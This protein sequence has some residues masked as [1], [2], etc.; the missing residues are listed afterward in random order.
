MKMTKKQ[1][2]LLSF[3][4]D[5][6][7]AGGPLPTLREMM[8]EF[9][10]SSTNGADDHVTALIRHGALRR[11]EARRGYGIVLTHPVVLRMLE[12]RKASA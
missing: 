12:E 11:P 9:G 6:Y 5:A 3:I 10:W 2:A 1:T 4:I 7:R 8:R